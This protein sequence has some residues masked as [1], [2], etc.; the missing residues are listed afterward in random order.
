MLLIRYSEKLLVVL[1]ALLLAT[2]PLQGAMASFGASDEQDGTG[3]HEQHLTD[4]LC[5]ASLMSGDTLSHDCTQCFTGNCCSGSECTHSQCGSFVTALAPNP[6]QRVWP[7]GDR[8]WQPADERLLSHVPPT[9][10]RPP[11]V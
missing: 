10:Y 1:L 4:D 8:H 9:L 6:L 11:R 2:S 5:G 3:S 7:V